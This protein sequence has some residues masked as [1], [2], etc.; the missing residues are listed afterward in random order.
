MNILVIG[1]GGREHAV[2]AA[3]AKSKRNPKIFAAPGNGGISEIATCLNVAATDIEGMKKAVAEHKI[4]FVFVTPDDPLAIGMVDEMEK[5]GVR[6]FGP[7]KAA[8]RIESSKVFSKNLMKKYGIPTAAYELFDDSI[9]AIEY[10]KSLNKYPAENQY[11][12]IFKN[13]D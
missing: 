11:T 4:D 6:A 13:V 7:N 9:K 8:A 1:S 12:E 5:I 2:I 10:I 3:L